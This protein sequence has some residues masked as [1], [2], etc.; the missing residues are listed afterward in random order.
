[1]HT[2][3]LQTICLSAATVDV[4]PDTAC[5]RNDECCD[6]DKKVTAIKPQLDVVAPPAS[7]EA[8][9]D[10]YDMGGYAGI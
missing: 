8:K 3:L 7:D 2:Y 10:D 9:N 5:T 6:T 1:M 4:E